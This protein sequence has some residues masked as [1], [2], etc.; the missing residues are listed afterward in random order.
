MHERALPSTSQK[1]LD[2]LEALNAPEIRGWVLAGGTGLALQL[3]HR[4]SEDFD[5]FRTDDMDVRSLHRVLTQVGSYETL[6]E[7]EHT[8]TVICMKIKLSFFR[9]RD[10]FVYKTV[11]YR[12]FDVAS[13]REIAL[14]KLIAI[15]GRGARKDFV[16]LYTILRGGESLRELFRALPKKY[17]AERANEY[18]ILKS[19]TYFAD[20]EEEPMPRLFEPFDWE[21]CKRFFIREVRALALN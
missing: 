15:S 19:L 8:L 14:M 1:L 11:P 13:P 16:D 18:H 3:G 6:Q 20:A 10:P 9:V 21:E 2:R 4:V 12:F 5:F 17:G 7:A